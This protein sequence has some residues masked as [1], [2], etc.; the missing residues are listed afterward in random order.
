MP[1][2]A[3]PLINT[4]LGKIR[5]RE[6]PNDFTKHIQYVDPIYLQSSNG[7]WSGLTDTSAAYQTAELKMLAKI[8]ALKQ[9]TKLL[10]N[11]FGS[12]F[13]TELRGELDN[14][15]TYEH[16]LNTLTKMG[17][18]D[19]KPFLGK[20]YTRAEVLAA[21]INWDGTTLESV[22]ESKNLWL[23][24]IHHKVKSV[25]IQ[26]NRLVVNVSCRVT[27]YPIQM[28]TLMDGIR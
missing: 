17:K 10:T 9:P 22:V 3:D 26:T 18:F 13:H 1:A 2:H 23:Y 19:T 15:L 27:D 16:V 11:L 28:L 14:T 7:L 25:Y 8:G 24:D 21:I 20:K 5:G 6:N 4:L 12:A